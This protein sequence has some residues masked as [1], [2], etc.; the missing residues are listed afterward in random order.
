MHAPQLDSAVWGFAAA[1]NCA[2]QLP[3]TP[4]DFTWLKDAGKVPSHAPKW[5][6]A[7]GAYPHYG[8]IHVGLQLQYKWM[9]LR[10]VTGGRGKATTALDLCI[11]AICSLRVLVSKTSQSL[12]SSAGCKR[13]T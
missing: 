6:G 7:R 1:V 12:Q 8:G 10:I 2:A 9:R 4:A 3:D 11:C 13:C 5:G